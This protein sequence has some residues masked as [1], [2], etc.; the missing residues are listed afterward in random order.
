VQQVLTAGKDQVKVW[1]AGIDA[2]EARQPHGAR[3][4][5]ALAELV[6][7]KPVQVEVVDTDRYGRPVV[8]VSAAGR[9]V[10][11]ELV[12]RGAAW[13]YQQYSHDSALL[14]VDAE[15]QAARRGLWALL[16]AE[17]MPPWEWRRLH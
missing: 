9:D 3:S 4:K 13:V 1:L 15:A 8:R 10:N 16:P 17:R 12:R 14:A 6:F 11:T 2:P 5:Q 7:Q